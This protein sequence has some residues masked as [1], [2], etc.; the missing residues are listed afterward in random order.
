LKLRNFAIYLWL[1]LPASATILTFNITDPTYP[2]SENFPEGF[3][4]NSDYGSR[5]TSTSQIAGTTTFSYGLGSEGFT[6]NIVVNYHPFSIFT[7]G[8]SL[9]RYDYGDLDRVLY[10]GSTSGPIGFN[11][12]YMVVELTADDGF[13]AV[14]HSF[15]VGAWFQTDRQVNSIAVYND[16]YSGFFPAQNR[17]F[18]DSNATILGTGPAHSSYSFSNPIRGKV[19]SILIDAQNLGDESELIGIDNIRFG[20]DR[21]VVPE[22]SPVGLMALGL[23]YCWWRR[24]PKS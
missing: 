17:V 7:G 24:R 12:D 14:L 18:L 5:V 2:N 4:L 19:I 20:Q 16:V 3:Q 22:P 9:W 13:E 1:A 10:Q 21:A 8:P 23:G 11:Y 6:P 15:D